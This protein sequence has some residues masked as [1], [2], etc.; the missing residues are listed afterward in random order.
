M[1]MKDID[2]SRSGLIVIDMQRYFISRSARAYIY[3]AAK[4]VPKI[5]SLIEIFRKY[6]L[7]VIFT[8]HA[9][10]RPQTTGQ[11]GLWWK[12]K[13]PWADNPESELINEI[14]PQHGEI[15][16]TKNQYSAFE[17]TNLNRKLKT[18]GIKTV[19]M[20]GVMTNLCVETSAR[21]A[22]MKG[23]QPIVIE[24]ACAANTNRHHRAA[25]LNLSYGFAYIVKTNDIINDLGN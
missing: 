12:N 5:L 9:H 19:V 3:G 1:K 16:L 10:K 18:R 23:L 4:I 24:D 20:C 15:L 11:M 13:L 17:G 8:R 22:F 7:P 6:R 14:V 2:Y 25:L 21:H